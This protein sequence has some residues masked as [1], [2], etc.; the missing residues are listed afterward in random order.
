MAAY[1]LYSLCFYNDTSHTNQVSDSHRTIYYS[2]DWRQFLS[3]F[4]QSLKLCYSI[5]VVYICYHY[6][7]LRDFFSV[8][9][10]ICFFD[11][12]HW[13]QKS[14]SWALQTK[15]SSRPRVFIVALSFDSSLILFIPG[16]IGICPAYSIIIVWFFW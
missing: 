5:E 6:L 11:S 13:L 12:W 14:I 9:Y 15:L 8:C 4:A 3:P 16:W 1:L 2:S 10:Y 7:S